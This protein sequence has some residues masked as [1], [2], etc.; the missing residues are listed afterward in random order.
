MRAGTLFFLLAILT[1]WTGCGPRPKQP[2]EASFEFIEHG[3]PAA[4][5]NPAVRAPTIS[6]EELKRLG[7]WRIVAV[8]KIGAK[9]KAREVRQR[10][11]E[12]DPK[13]RGPRPVQ[14]AYPLIV[15]ETPQ[16][17]ELG[18]TLSGL[19][20]KFN[21]EGEKSGIAVLA[22]AN[23]RPVELVHFSRHKNWD[24]ASLLWRDKES[25]NLTALYLGIDGAG[26]GAG[27]GT[28]VAGGVNGTGYLLPPA[29]RWGAPTASLSLCGLPNERLKNLVREAAAQWQ[30]ALEGRLKIE[31]RDVPKG[32]PPFS[33]I[34]FNCVYWVDGYRPTPN[35]RVRESG[36]T[37]LLPH[38][39]G[40]L[41]MDADI[42]FYAAEF[43]KIEA[44]S[45]TEKD[46]SQLE[47]FHFTALHEIGHWLGLDHPY[48]EGEKS[49]MSYEGL[50]ELQEYDIAKIQA[51][52]PLNPLIK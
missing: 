12:Q 39:W 52:Y 13:K 29:G 27:A 23:R 3:D 42:F 36:T 38:P 28:S 6:V 19:H 45:E 20:L 30:K 35:A 9:S 21:R 1:F 43:A 25:G 33:D 44:A 32:Y 41:I 46:K 26:A 11:E 15:T 17:L 40:N 16:S 51:L 7:G 8:V 24:L 5:L 47:S 31:I 2:K 37:K 22:E 4:F 34:N 10:R 50:R 49:V 18:D 48:R 14:K